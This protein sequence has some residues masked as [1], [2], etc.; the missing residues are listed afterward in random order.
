MDNLEYRD[1]DARQ[2][3]RRWLVLAVSAVAISGVFAVLI[4]LARVPAV[5]ALF[6]GAEFYRV[7]LVLHVNL[8]QGVWFMAFAGVMWSLSSRGGHDY[9]ERLS[10]GLA[11]IGTAGLVLSVSAGSVQPVMSN[12]LPV[13]DSPLFLGSLVLFGLGVLLKAGLS[14]LGIRL[15]DAGSVEVLAKRMLLKLAAAA[16]VAVFGLLVV[17]WLIMA[18]AEGMAFFETL[19]W[20]GGHLWQFTLICLLMYC[21]LSFASR[22]LGK[23]QEA[24]L[25]AALL[26]SLIPIVLSLG[27]PVFHAPE[28]AGSVYL[29]TW[30]MRW[31]SWQAPLLVAFAVLWAAP[32]SSLAPGFQLSL[33]LFLAGLLIGATINGQTT[34]IT[35]HY[36]GTIGAITLAFMAFSF[37]ILPALG[38]ASP[39]KALVRW[40]L[41]FYGYGILLMMLGLAGAGW[42]GAPRKTPGDLTLAFNIE[43]FSRI[44]LGIGGLCATIGILMFA[45]LLLRRLLHSS[46]VEVYSL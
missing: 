10:L 34:L 27:I 16:S 22:R 36:H 13:L 1:D 30:L 19:F 38:L 26:M 17:T 24:A 33:L 25:S 9:L 40:Q 8:A 3:A 15:S 35:A 43:T 29:Y 2:W 7:A 37:V 41:G 14:V 18:P 5:G 4:A 46:A 31:T 21:W 23:T 28:S 6:P 32:R 20:G 12:Y 45:W 11:V 44:C 39:P 42:M